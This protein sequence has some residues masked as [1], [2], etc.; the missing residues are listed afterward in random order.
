MFKNA[1]EVK[2]KPTKAAKKKGAEVKVVDLE[3]LATVKALI[4]S[5]EAI[6]ETLDE[7]VKDQ[8][9]DHFVKEGMAID[10]RP[11][12]Y[13]GL[14]GNANGSLQLRVRNNRSPLTGEE[15]AQ[16]EDHEIPF[17]VETVVEETYIIN[18]AYAEDDDLLSKV[19]DVLENI[20]GIP[21][22]FIQHQTGK[23]KTIATEDS[24]NA[25][26]ALKNETNVKNLLAVVGT[27][28]TRLKTSE[29]DPQKLFD[30]IAKMI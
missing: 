29:A 27:L 21:A 24:L 4:K 19:G 1:E 2:A 7:S 16:L 13:K 28:A 6:E 15:I 17:T 18:P 23:T 10:R 20:D 3:A 26:F 12:N 30:V 5:L 22:D 8:M 14:E 11:E 9:S 25:I